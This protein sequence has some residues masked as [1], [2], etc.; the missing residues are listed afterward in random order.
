MTEELEQINEIFQ[1]HLTN[2][3]LGCKV[4]DVL[5]WNSFQIMEFMA[6]M[7]TRYSVDVTIERIA[8]IDTVGDLICLVRQCRT[9]FMGV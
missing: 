6:E 8:G 1:S 7:D 9:D 5:E 2:V 4:E 3:D